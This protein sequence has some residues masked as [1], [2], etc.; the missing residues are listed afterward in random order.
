[1]LAD[2]LGVSVK[3]LE[4]GAF[5]QGTLNECRSLILCI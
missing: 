4:F 2:P 5:E 1:M 3:L